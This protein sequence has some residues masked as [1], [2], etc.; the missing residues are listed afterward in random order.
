M[1]YI[2]DT[3]GEI[4][5]LSLVIH[6]FSEFDVIFLCESTEKRGGTRSGFERRDCKMAA[7]PRVRRIT[8]V[9]PP[10][11]KRKSIQKSTSKCRTVEKAIPKNVRFRIRRRRDYEEAM[12]LKTF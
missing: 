11:A 8:N 10:G 5:F 12:Q 9:L 6:F 3:V 2:I 1:F 7:A 4:P